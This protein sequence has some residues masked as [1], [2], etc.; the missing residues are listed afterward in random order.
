MRFLKMKKKKK[1]LSTGL[2]PF[3]SSSPPHSLSLLL[4]LA[5]FLSFC[6]VTYR[7]VLSLLSL[8]MF[9]SV[10]TIN[11]YI[12]KQIKMTIACFALL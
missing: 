11:I 12:I 8:I 6:L 9:F 5:L 2:V 10:H 4:S 7:T 3:L 1:M